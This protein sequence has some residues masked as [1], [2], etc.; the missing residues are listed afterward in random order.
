MKEGG[1]VLKTLSHCHHHGDTPH[2]VVEVVL[3]RDAAGVATSFDSWEECIEC[4][5]EE[6]KNE[7]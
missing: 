2:R 4:L 6:E 5:R 1:S 7:G 3:D